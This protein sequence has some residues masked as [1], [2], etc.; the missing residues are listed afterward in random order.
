[1]WLIVKIRLRLLGAR[2]EAPLHDW[3]DDAA[4]HNGGED[5]PHDSKDEAM[6]W[7]KFRGLRDGKHGL[8]CCCTK[9][10]MKRKRELEFEA[11][12]GV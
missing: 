3:H 1:M 8:L 2:R 10:T 7:A 11:R 6:G 5:N 12:P 4:P 9:T